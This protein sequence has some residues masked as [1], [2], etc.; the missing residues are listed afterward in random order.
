M[1]AGGTCGAVRCVPDSRRGAGPPRT[2]GVTVRAFQGVDGGMDPSISMMP[3]PIRTSREAATAAN[4]GRRR[5]DAAADAG[6]TVELEVDPTR[7]AV[8]F[9]AKQHLILGPPGR[10]RDQTSRSL[11]VCVCVCGCGRR[12]CRRVLE[13]VHATPKHTNV[14]SHLRHARATTT[15]QAWYL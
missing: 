7:P 11:A 1:A 8:S 9:A 4:C 13:Q 3:R 5:L 12:A 6:G 14:S 10:T 2:T 15:T